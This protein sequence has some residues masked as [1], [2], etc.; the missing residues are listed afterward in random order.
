M[1]VL[2]KL[3]KTRGVLRT[4]ITK[5]INKIE[6]DFKEKLD[7]YTVTIL[8]EYLKYLKEVSKQLK[9]SDAEIQKLKEDEN[10]F[11]SEIETAVEYSK[12]IIIYS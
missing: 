7:S 3:K 10:D 1:D 8:E 6:S 4:S 5:Y 2:S 9:D 12:K 11:D